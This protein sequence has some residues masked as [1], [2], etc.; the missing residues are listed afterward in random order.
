MRFNSV[1]GYY[2]EI[3]RTHLA[4]V[5]ADYLRKQTVANAERYVTPEL[6]ELEQKILTAEERRIA[7]EVELFTALRAQVA[8]AAERLLALARRAGG[9][10]RAGLARRGRAP[11]RATAGPRS[12]TA[13]SSISP[14]RAIP[15][16]SGWPPP[17]ASCRTTSAS[18]RAASRS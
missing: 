16:S 7:L 14:T 13:A 9:G 6:A 5:P 4:S 18:I 1:F 8:A 11:Q 12:T 17:A 3:T 2:I 10:R 15:S